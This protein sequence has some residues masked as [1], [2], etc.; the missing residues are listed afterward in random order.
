MKP[1]SDRETATLLRMP[2]TGETWC[3]FQGLLINLFKNKNDFLQDSRG[4]PDFF[5]SKRL[6]QYGI[7]T[8]ACRKK[9]IKHEKNHRPGNGPG[10]SIYS[11][12]TNADCS[13]K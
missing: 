10:G 3:F 4:V 13:A 12:V 8:R 11:N 6:S 5:I 7:T 1:H 2:V 9:K